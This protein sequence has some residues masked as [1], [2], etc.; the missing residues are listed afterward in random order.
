MARE[1]FQTLSE[2]MYYVL[3]SLTEERYGAQIME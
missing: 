1:A 3:L 2:P